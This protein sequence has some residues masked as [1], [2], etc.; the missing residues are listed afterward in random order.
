MT[1]ELW[2]GSCKFGLLSVLALC[3]TLVSTLDD[4]AFAQVEVDSTLGN[5]SSLVT[6]NGNVENL[7][8][9]GGATRGVNL[10]HSFREF[11]VGANRSVNFA[12][13]Q[14][15]TDIFSRVTG[16]NR[17][18]IL[19]NLGV[20]GDANLF[21]INP[22]GIIFGPNANLNVA[23]SFFATTADSFVFDNG[24]QFS[25][26][27]PQAAPLLSVSVT[28]GLQFGANAGDIA[29]SADLT[30]GKDFTLAG[31]NLDVRG[32]LRASEGLRLQAQDTAKVAIL[33]PGNSLS[34]DA[35][36]KIETTGEINTSINGG[37]GGN[38]NLTSGAGGIDTSGGTVTAASDNGEGGNITLTASSDIT[39]AD[40][41]SF[42]GDSG[43]GKAGDITIESLNGSINIDGEINSSGFGNELNSGQGGNISLTAS[44]NITTAFVGSYI[45]VGG[46][47]DGG[48]ITI[49]SRNGN[50]TTADVSSFIGEGGIGNGG[51]IT[52]DS[53]KGNINTTAGEIKSSGFG[54]ELNPRKG[55]DIRLEASGNITTAVVSSSIGNPGIGNDLEDTIPDGAI[56]KGGDITIKSIN[57]NIDTTAGDIVGVNSVGFGT[58]T[59]PGEGGDIVLEASGDITT[60]YVGSF[61]KNGGVGRAGDVTIESTSGKFSLK[62]HQIRTFTSSISESGN[63]NITA[64]SVL[65]EGAELSAEAQAQGTAGSVSVKANQSISLKNGSEINASFDPSDFEYIYLEE[66]SANNITLEANSIDLSGASIVKTNTSGSADAGDVNINAQNLKITG[67]SQVQSFT[68][69]TGKAGNITINYLTDKDSS[70]VSLDKA[71]IFSTIE[72]GAE[73]NSDEVSKVSIDAGSL[74]LEN[75]SQ[76]QTLVRG[77]DSESDSSKIPGKG[78]AGIIDIDV[79]DSVTLD[80][81]GTAI[82]SRLGQGTRG[83]GGDIKIKARSLSLNNGAQIDSSTF[84]QGDAGDIVVN[85]NTDNGKV[86]LTNGSRIIAFVGNT[87]DGDGGNI[88]ITARSLFLKEGA[89]IDTSTAGQGSAGSITV[90]AINDVSLT[91]N[92]TRILSTAQAASQGSAGNI[93]IDPKR[94]T[95]EK[96][97]EIKVDD[98]K[99]EGD[100]N[101]AAGS[102]TL[103]GDRLTLDNGK[104]TAETQAINGGDINLNVKDL[105]LLRKNSFVSATAGQQGKGGNVTIEAPNGFI[106]SAPNEN[107]DIQ[108]NASQG[109]GGLVDITAKGVYWLAP[110]SRKQLFEKLTESDIDLDIDENRTALNLNTNDITAISQEGAPELDGSV[111]LN[112]PDVDPANSITALP[113]DVVD[114]SNQIDQ[115]CAAFDEDAASEFRITGRGG[116]PPS[117]DQPLNS[118]TVWEDTRTTATAPQNLRANTTV[119]TSTV[120]ANKITPAAGWV[121]KENGE[122]TLVASASK[123]TPEKLGSA[124]KSCPTR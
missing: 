24:L 20:L 48:N 5:E 52:I 33:T 80:G 23:G 93:N 38:I 18:N 32:E 8:I 42:I 61:M 54:R 40:V 27:N 100:K 69:G 41:S 90:K 45:G 96:G 9:E 53:K 95:I 15:I 114:P 21:L 47:G 2:R 1:L 109:N 101:A 91:G 102:I 76:I 55:G 78:N 88:E 120:E 30:V 81:V 110:L 37:K 117:P 31:G 28:P 10:F 67:D 85:A 84:G 7:L 66:S 49:T 99:L 58:F 63:I 103:A 65:L 106:A 92:E 46:I 123:A 79:S 68:S 35:G 74:D 83:K 12:N 119:K 82:T 111:D 22:N 19:G 108:G 56:G 70:S 57:G 121:F 29:S 124:P 51:N 44:G 64:E 115:G 87:G 105:F 6:P 26:N 11:N 4:S 34:I 94:I 112:T 89:Q 16:S 116:L 73:S 98:R 77:V 113:A 86:E 104:I 39:T 118:N 62:G 25:A 43:V 75:N 13:P 71:I 97:A 59:T 50:I 107:N 122:V 3:N 60:A 36:N 17:S 72:P 14:G